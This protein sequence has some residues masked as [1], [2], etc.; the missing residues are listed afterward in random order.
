MIPPADTDCVLETSR[1]R[2]A[3]M[4]VADAA[5]LFDLLKHADLHVFTGDRPPTRLNELRDRIASREGRLSPD[6]KE[7]WLNW[8]IRLRSE[9]SVAGYIQAGIEEGRADLAWV[10]GL[11]FQGHGYATEAA[12]AVVNWLR[13]HLR[14]RELRATI[15]PDNH[16]SQAVAKHI[17][18]TLTA[19]I[20]G[21][22]EELWARRINRQ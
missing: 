21:E 22:G 6:E 14:V 12:S 8:T 4:L 9:P 18:L 19:E 13:D 5:E 11:P 20:T 1:L 15:H 3:P 10:V 7:V 17:G 2:L 16:A